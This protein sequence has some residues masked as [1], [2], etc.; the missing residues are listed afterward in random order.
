[1]C[2]REANEDKYKMHIEKEKAESSLR[3]QLQTL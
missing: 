1:M 3:K 2:L